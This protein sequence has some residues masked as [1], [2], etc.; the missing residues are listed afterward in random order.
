M[1]SSCAKDSEALGCLNGEGQS[2]YR[3][4]GEYCAEHMFAWSIFSFYIIAH[5]E[6]VRKKKDTNTTKT[7]TKSRSASQ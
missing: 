2:R 7:C 3:Q 4:W 5:E 1:R 6:F